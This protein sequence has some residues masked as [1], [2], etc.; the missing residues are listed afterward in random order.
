MRPINPTPNDIR[1]MPALPKQYVNSLPTRHP[2]RAHVEWVVRDEA[3][4]A[5]EP[6][7]MVFADSMLA[8][9]VRVRYRAIV[10]ILSESGCSILGLAKVWG[11]DRRSIQRALK[12]AKHDG[13]LDPYRL[14]S[15]RRAVA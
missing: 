10:R 2:S 14:R 5:G 9:I 4:R 3:D 8:A 6:P 15:E 13:R 7:E 1:A 11:V 12:L